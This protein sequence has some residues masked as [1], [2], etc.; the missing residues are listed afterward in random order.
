[1]DMVLFKDWFSKHFLHHVGSGRPLLLLMDGHSSH[2]NLEA[3][4]L[5]K[6]N[7]I[8]LFTLVTHMTHQMQPLDMAVYG[9]LKTNWQDVC[10]HYFQSHPGKVIMKYQF[11]QLF[12]ETWLKP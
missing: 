4:T 11:N 5:A 6:E 12:S 3:V 1:M 9:P 8:I 10:H 7:D 2:Y